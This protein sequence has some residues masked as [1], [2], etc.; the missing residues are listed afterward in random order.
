MFSFNLLII[1]LDVKFVTLSVVFH[2][3]RILFCLF[4]IVVGNM[5]KSAY[6]CFSITLIHSLLWKS[7]CEVNQ[8]DDIQSESLWEFGDQCYFH[9]DYETARN[10]FLQTATSVNAELKNIEILPG[11]FTDVAILK[12][13]SSKY[14]FHISGVHGIDLYFSWLQF[15]NFITIMFGRS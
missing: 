1:A 2:L 14:L 8:C 9:D 12:G 4:E 15:H 6:Y 10:R 5:N 13:G 3:F 11:L 7:Y